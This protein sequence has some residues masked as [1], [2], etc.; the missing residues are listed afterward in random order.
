MAA[1]REAYPD[2]SP[3]HLICAVQTVMMM[4]AN[5][6]TLAEHKAARRAAP[7]F[8]YM[9]TWETPVARGLLKSQHALE[10]RVEND[11]LSKV[12]AVLQGV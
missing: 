6:V 2:Y 1:L 11:P 7:V 4:W 9:M 5:S 10:S 12:R 3:T 8:L